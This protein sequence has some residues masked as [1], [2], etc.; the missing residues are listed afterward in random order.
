MLS[1]QPW[2]RWRDLST[3]WV[4]AQRHSTAKS[5]R[6][7]VS[8][9][10]DLARSLA[11]AKTLAEILELRTTY[12]RKQLTALAAQAEEVR[13]LSAKVAADCCGHSPG[14]LPLVN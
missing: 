11:T 2:T 9:G 1:K 12:W 5:S 3:R 10:F 4:R 8:S 7:N 14:L 13:A 6:S